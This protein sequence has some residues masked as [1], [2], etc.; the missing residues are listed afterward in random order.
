MLV[1]A[2]LAFD[3]DR[4]FWL[5]AFTG[6]R[7]EHTGALLNRLKGVANTFAPFGIYLAGPS[8]RR[9]PDSSDLAVSLH[10]QPDTWWPVHLP[11][12]IIV[13]RPSYFELTTVE[14]RRITRGGCS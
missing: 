7:P 14:S 4:D 3:A 9:I 6:M 2:R 10:A 11:I 1:G 5:A 13:G 12:T 8:S